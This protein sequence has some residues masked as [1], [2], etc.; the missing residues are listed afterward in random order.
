MAAPS[1]FILSKSGAGL[2]RSTSCS[3]RECSGSRRIH[4]PDRVDARSVTSLLP[5]ARCLA[6]TGEIER[7]RAANA[8]AGTGRSL[9]GANV[10]EGFV[11]AL[12]PPGSQPRLTTVGYG[13]ISPVTVAGRYVGIGFLVLGIIT[14]GFSFSFLLQVR[15]NLN[16]T[17]E[18]KQTLASRSQPQKSMRVNES[19]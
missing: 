16:S 11:V 14:L 7:A 5:S 4:P 13:D 19:Q 3:L 2:T 1:R 8:G 6:M 9:S 10:S 12:T 18:R 17:C 15:V